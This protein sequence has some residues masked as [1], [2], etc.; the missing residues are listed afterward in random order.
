TDCLDDLGI[1]HLPSQTNFIMHRIRGELLTY[2]NRMM[3]AGF[4]VGRPFPPML[5]WSRLSMGM[6]DDM[7][8]FAETLRD[9]RSKDWI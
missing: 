9:F 3:D 2:N 8:R 5:D 4:A 6:P 7:A 1:E